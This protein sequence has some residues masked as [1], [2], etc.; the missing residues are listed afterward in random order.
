MPAGDRPPGDLGDELRAAVTGAASV[1]RDIADAV[2]EVPLDDA[3]AVLD[4]LDLVHT[5]HWRELR[6]SLATM[7]RAQVNQ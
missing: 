4:W 2:D 3:E 7:R 6:R 1:L 5:H